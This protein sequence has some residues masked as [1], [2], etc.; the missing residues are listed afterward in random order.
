[1][2]FQFPT[3]GRIHI[4]VRCAVQLMSWQVLGVPTGAP[5]GHTLNSVGPKARHICAVQ[6]AKAVDGRRKLDRTWS[7]KH[8]LDLHLPEFS[9]KTSRVLGL[10]H[11]PQ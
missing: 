3:N 5:G 1:M 11:S 8:I 4:Q 10:P 7:F 6:A 2:S 9:I